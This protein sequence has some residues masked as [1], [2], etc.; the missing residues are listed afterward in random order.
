MG[1]VVV[2]LSNAYAVEVVFLMYPGALDL[3]GWPIYFAR[4]AAMGALL[5]SALMYLTMSRSLLRWMRALR[6]AVVR[7]AL[8]AHREAHVFCGQCLF[9]CAF[10]HIV[11]HVLGTVTALQKH[12]S[13][14]V[15]DVI[16]C[17]SAPS[18]YLGVEFRWLTWPTCPLEPDF[19]KHGFL[20]ILFFRT[21][22]TASGVALTLCLFLLAWTARADA[23]SHYFDRFIHVHNVV[24]T[25]WPLLLFIHGATGMLGVGLPL[26]IFVCG[27]PVCFYLLDRVL[28]L[29]RYYLFTGKAVVIEHAVVRE[30]LQSPLDGSL[31]Y[32]RITKP[33]YLWRQKH[34]MYAFLCFPTY[35]WFQWHPFTICSETS[36]ETVDFIIAGVGDWTRALT[37]A[38]I[39]ARTTELLPVVAL[40]GPYPAPTMSAL[41]HEVVIA[42]G[43]GV[44]ITP[45]L[46]LMSTF[47]TRVERQQTPVVE[48]H[49]YWMTRSAE[50]FLFGRLVFKR[51]SENPALKGKFFLHLHVTATAP[52]KDGS[53]FLFRQAVQRQSALDRAALKR[54]DRESI[55]TLHGFSTPWAWVNRSELDAVW[56]KGLVAEDEQ[57]DFEEMQKAT[58]FMTTR[59]SK[60]SS[61]SSS[62]SSTAANELSL[63]DTGV[64]R[65]GTMGVPIFL[66][67]P[68]FAKEL[69]AIG[70]RNAAC[71]VHVYVCGNSKIVESCRAVCDACNLEQCGQRFVLHFERFGG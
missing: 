29:L 17:A 71:N 60:R 18:G 26:V 2:L 7:T 22:A 38:C 12:T 1:A 55:Q 44:G 57:D 63:A 5:W 66:G 43:A 6:L 70:Q 19:Q 68:E 49:F 16:G 54:L 65:E 64:L 46:S 36:S 56:M 31:L 41:K 25:L 32:L 48:A 50:E 45:F 11:A 42:V 52:S 35:S 53:A 27:L 34:G 51:L 28:R 62:K 47:C 15:N 67:R 61:R 59:N 21:S 9:I 23:R 13:E 40:D 8:D 4:A 3:F 30:G 37:R 58:T 20:E 39:D 69:P 14:E 33:P 24:F 10:I